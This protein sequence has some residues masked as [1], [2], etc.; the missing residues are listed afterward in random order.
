MAAAS[1]LGRMG[2]DAKSAV[3]A[4]AAALQVPGE[5]VQVLRNAC[6]ALG[7]IGPD[8]ASAIPALKQVQHLR[9][10]YIAQEAI[11]KIEGK[12]FPTWH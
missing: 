1:A 3:P 8:A 12:P 5:E 4:L 7:D 11:A 6:Y 2:K 10:I 9:V